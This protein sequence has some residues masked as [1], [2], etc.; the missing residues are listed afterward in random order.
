[1][2][3]LRQELE[4]KLSKANADLARMAEAVSVAEKA[5]ATAKEEGSRQLAAAKDAAQ[6]AAAQAAAAAETEAVQRAAKAAEAA[7][8]AAAAEVLAVY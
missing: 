4:S 5:T 1:M 3:E 7:T 8:S 6:S 2:A